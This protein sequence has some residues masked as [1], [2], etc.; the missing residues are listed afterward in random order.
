MLA[1]L[2][3][4]AVRGLRAERVDVEVDLSSGLPSFLLVGLPDKA[5]EESKERVRSAIKNSGAIFPSRR[6]TVGLAPADF[7]KEGPAYDLPIAIGILT[8]SEQVELPEGALFLGELALG[9]ELRPIDGVLT[10]ALEAERLGYR[11]LYLPAANADEASLVGNLTIYPLQTLTELLR[12]LHGEVPIT[13]HRPARQQA[14]NFTPEIDFSHIQGQARAKRALE[15]AAAG[16]HNLLLSGPPGTGKT[17]LARA[18]SGILPAM[19]REEQLAVTQIYSLVGLIDR[20]A[21]LV[22]KRPIRSPHH[23]SSGI[24]LTGGGAN[25]RPGEVSLAHHG[26][27]YLDELAEFSRSV[28]EVLRQPLEE[29][30]ITVSRAAGSLYFPCRF[31]LVASAN[32][33]PCGYQSDPE[34]PCTC[35]MSQIERYRRR[36]SGPLLDRI[37][38]RLEVPRLSYDELTTEAVAESS[39]SVRGRVERARAAQRERLGMSRTNSTLQVEE[40]TRHCAVGAEESALLRQAVDHYRLSARAYHRVLKVARTI[41]D[42]EGSEEITLPHLSEAIGYRVELAS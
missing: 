14:P 8:A 42:L 37:D 3:S 36:V 38:L 35:S 22:T 34:K 29:G 33:C 10:V 26:V 39:E 18:L 12:H 11:A 13:P 30:G 28:L 23:T 15:I 32:P 25:P 31:T 1:R 21:P 7:K 27:L 4:V 17:L 19:T 16:G 41:A 2:A 6:I 40:I 9:G 20:G 24:A 5:I